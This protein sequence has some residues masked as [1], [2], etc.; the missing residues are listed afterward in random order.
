MAIELFPWLEIHLP[1]HNVHV[2]SMCVDAIA[3]LNGR[4]LAAEPRFLPS[5]IGQNTSGSERTSWSQHLA[6]LRSQIGSGKHINSFWSF[7]G[8]GI[9]RQPPQNSAEGSF[10]KPQFAHAEGSAAPQRAQ[11]RLVAAFSAMQLG[12][13]IWWPLGA[14]PSN[15]DDERMMHS[16]GQNCW[17]A[18]A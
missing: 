8:C 1:R 2:Y 14:R 3:H 13:R 16:T 15:S 5:V 9:A 4:R 6:K 10:S 17:I 18:P 12:Q 11:K 7:T